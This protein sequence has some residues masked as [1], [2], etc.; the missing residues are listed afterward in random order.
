MAVFGSTINPALGRVD[1]SPLAQGLA[2]GGQLAAQGIAGFGQGVTQGVQSFLKKQE[3]KKNELEGIEFIKNQIP[4]IDDAAAKAGLK[5]AGG[6]AAF[7]KFKSDMAAQADADRMRALQLAEMERRAADQA[8][9][10]RFAS[11]L[12][13]GGGQVPSPVSNQAIAQISP[14][15]RMAGRSAYL[16]QARAQAELEQTQA[17]TRNLLQKPLQEAPIGYRYTKSGELEEIPGGP[18]AAA[19][20]REEA[21]QQIALR[22][23]ARQEELLNL[24]IG[25]AQAEA[26]DEAEKKRLAEEAKSAAIED[27]KLSAE[28]TLRE[29]GKARALIDQ[30]FAQGF[31]SDVAGFFGGTAANDLETSYDVIRANEALGRIIALKKASPTGSTGFGALNLKELETL[32]SRFAKLTRKTSDE[33][34]RTALNDL[35]KVIYKAYPDLRERAEL[36]MR[37]NESQRA[38]RGPKIGAGS[39]FEVIEVSR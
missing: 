25:R 17:Q 16:Q 27:A 24:Q 7:V 39:R 12:E 1:Y 11:L 30:P 2:M 33:S 4:G 29:V 37:N 19:R 32:Q 5:A 36:E 8:G 21:A 31:G 15:A 22:S 18:A 38:S 28:T 23:A 34:A 13:Q 3:E 35:E 20:K 6:A 10:A 9:A 26:K 14:E